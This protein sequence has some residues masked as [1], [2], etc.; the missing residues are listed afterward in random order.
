MRTEV[1]PRRN[2]RSGLGGKFGKADRWSARSSPT[3]GLTVKSHVNRFSPTLLVIHG[4]SLPPAL[5]VPETLRMTRPFA[6][7]MSSDGF[8]F[9]FSF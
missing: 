2:A 4:T 5:C 7:R 1:V 6:S 9:C 3:G 8:P